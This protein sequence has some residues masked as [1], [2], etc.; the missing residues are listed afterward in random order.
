LP[1]RTAR[2]DAAEGSNPVIRTA[3]KAWHPVFSSKSRFF[4]QNPLIFF[5]NGDIM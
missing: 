1:C 3:E 5:G 4:A 2:V